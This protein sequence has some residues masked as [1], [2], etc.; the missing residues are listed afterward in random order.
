[1]SFDVFIKQAVEKGKIIFPGK[2]D[3]YGF[4][5]TCEEHQHGEKLKC[6]QC[7]RGSKS[8]HSFS[9]QYFND[10]V[11][12]DSVEFKSEWN[13]TFEF[14]AHTI[15]VLEKT[16]GL[17]SID[18][19]VTLKQTNDEVGM[20]VTKVPNDGLIYVLEANGKHMS[21]MDLI[22]ETFRLL[23]IYNIYKV[24]IETTSA[25][26][27]FVSL[28]K[29]EMI[30]RKKFFTIE[31]VRS[32]T[33]ETKPARIRGL[34]PYYSNGRILHR[35]GL[36]KL[37]DQLLQFPR[38]VHDDVIDALAHQVKYW[39]KM[40]GKVKLQGKAPMWSLDWW[41]KQERPVDNEMER[42]FGDII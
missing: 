42:L 13:R 32:S 39:Q 16:R 38:N 37:E 7:L 25:Q 23:D 1:M 14:D 15:K 30:K 29:Q 20:V 22:N 4:C 27:L 9:A 21:P 17:L 3:T 24:L 31:E 41:K 10:P 2:K 35:K 28:F 40:E 36:N 11:D 18:P 33:R 8:A 12:A 19:A 5:Q 26:I 6:L 34:I